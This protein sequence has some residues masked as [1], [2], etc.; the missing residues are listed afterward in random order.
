M[1]GCIA[2]HANDQTGL[3]WPGMGTIATETGFCRRAVV[4]AI[5]ELERGEHFTVGRFKV[6]KKNKRKSGINFRRWV[7]HQPH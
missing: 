6:G 3:G 2:R 1:A 4:K 7:V 5:K